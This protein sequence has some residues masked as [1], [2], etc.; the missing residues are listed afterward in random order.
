MKLE[1]T[2]QAILI[3]VREPKEFRDFNIPGSINLPSSKYMQQDYEPYKAMT[4][5]LVCQ[6]GNRAK[7][8]KTKLNA[9]G[10]EG[11]FILEKQI[12]DL[13]AHSKPVKKR[14]W[15]VDRQFRM[16]LG[17]LLA[18]FLVGFYFEMNGFVIIPAILATGLIFTSLIDRCYLRMGIA[19]LPWNREKKIV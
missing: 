4:I 6:T 8:I 16:L 1:Q 14:K 7:T 11:V 15:S 13:V 2:Q 12:G 3:D 19:M 10:F 17:I 9:T 18:I 5:C